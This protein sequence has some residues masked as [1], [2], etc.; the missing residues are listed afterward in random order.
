MNKKQVVISV[1]LLA[2]FLLTAVG[3]VSAQSQERGSIRGAV[4][5]DVNGDGICVGTGIAGENPVAG[6]TIEFVSSDEATVLTLQTGSDGTYGLVAAGQS[7]WRVTVQPSTEW[8]V[9][10]VNPLYPPVLPDT[11]LIQTDVNFCV[12]RGAT[13]GNAVIILPESGGAAS[14]N[15]SLIIPLI[16]MAGAS[17]F[18]VGVG[19]EWKRR[20]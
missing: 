16:G 5:T 2:G 20:L 11:G 3:L 10:S 1:L 19:L 6:V 13:D 17:L 15:L 12:S 8:R 7:I 14:S 18:A 9:T 4:Y